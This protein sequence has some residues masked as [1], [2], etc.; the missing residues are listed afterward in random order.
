MDSSDRGTTVDADQVS[1]SGSI[2]FLTECIQF[3]KIMQTDSVIIKLK[4]KVY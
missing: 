2:L 4:Q 1:Y 3:W